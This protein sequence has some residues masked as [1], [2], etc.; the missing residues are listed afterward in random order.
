MPQPLVGPEHVRK[1]L[2]DDPET[3][4]YADTLCCPPFVKVWPRVPAKTV[5]NE[6]RDGA[7]NDMKREVREE[8]R[9]LTRET[10]AKNQPQGGSIA[11]ATGHPNDVRDGSR[12]RHGGPPPGKHNASG[13]RPT[14]GKL[15][16]SPDG[17]P[18]TLV[19]GLHGVGLG[20][21]ASE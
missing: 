18:Q 19:V 20:P 2:P 6:Y 10:A 3:Q 8:Q 1:D 9:K 16:L 12:H 17:Y 7:F 15:G 21:S 14:I 4:P 13:R 5:V 11:E